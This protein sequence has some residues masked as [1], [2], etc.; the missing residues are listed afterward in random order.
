MLHR[1][2]VRENEPAGVSPRMS[3]PTKMVCCDGCNQPASAEHIAL[4][5][6]RLELATRFRPIH[7]GIL[8]LAEAPPPRLEDYFYSAA[9]NAGERADLSRVLFDSLMQGLGV[10]PQAGANDASCL[11]E[12]QKRGYFLA[13]SM[14]C[15]MAE[16]VPGQ[17]EGATEENAAE[18]AQR[19]GPTVVKRVR[20]SYKPRHIVLLS[21]RTRH[22]IPILQQAGLGDRLLLYQGHPLR[23]PHPNNPAAQAESRAGLAD[24]LARAAARTPIE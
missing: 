4:R 12:F 2:D 10:A 20:F 1:P 3:E 19:Y 11:A 6:Q 21:T 14:E 9:E 18:L 24:V 13:D 15:P 23:F 5:L 8:F 16:I 22:L 7:I 17:R